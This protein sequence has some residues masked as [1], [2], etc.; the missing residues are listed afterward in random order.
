MR[1]EDFRREFNEIKGL[2]RQLIEKGDSNM[3]TIQ[4]AFA[5][6]QQEVQETSGVVDSALV[7]IQ[8]LKDQIAQLIAS[9]TITPEQLQTLHDQLDAKEQ[10]LAGAIASEPA[11]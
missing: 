2:L 5:A 7:F 9:G 6:L 4:E 11:P 3:A 10:A 1:E 8:G